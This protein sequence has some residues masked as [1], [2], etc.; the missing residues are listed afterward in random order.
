[1]HQNAADPVLA[2]KGTLPARIVRHI[3]RQRGSLQAVGFVAGVYCSL[4]R[5]LAGVAVARSPVLQAGRGLVLRGCG[6]AGPFLVS[7]NDVPLV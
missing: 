3:E 1:M 6:C 5:W 7:G 4:G 2:Q